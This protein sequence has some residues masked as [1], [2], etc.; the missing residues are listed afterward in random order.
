MLET[1]ACQ[2]ITKSVESLHTPEES[3]CCGKL[4]YELP[5]EQQQLVSEH[6]LEAKKTVNFEPSIHM[7]ATQSL[8]AER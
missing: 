7:G 1:L 6:Y 3:R 2:K 8:K 5:S 4:R